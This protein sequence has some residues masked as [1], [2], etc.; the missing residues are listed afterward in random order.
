MIHQLTDP[1]KAAKL[2][3]GMEDTLILSCL[4][5]LMGKIYADDPESPR[6][7]MASLGC[8]AIYAG[9]PDRELV[10]AKPDG[11]LIMVPQNDSWTALIE[12]CFPDAEKE[13]RY[14]I[15]KDT[16]FCREK[17]EAMAAALPLGY[18]LRKI[19]AELYDKCLEDPQFT[20]FVYN[21]G[22]K[23]AFRKLG[24]GMVILKDGKIVSG[25]SSFSRYDKGIEIE[26]DTDEEE[27]RKGLASAVCAALIL[28]C[29]DEGLYPSWDAANMDSVRLAEKL[30]YEFSHEYICYI[31][32]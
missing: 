14:A 12:S 7:A 24:R 23:E 2:F 15:R 29:L 31:S 28:S 8:F 3:E 26:V 4:Q 20:D 18:E 6:S 9:E 30:G 10:M 1:S 22:S 19:D 32:E 11:F 25:A 5:N 17:L 27:R 16:K 13:T 21:F